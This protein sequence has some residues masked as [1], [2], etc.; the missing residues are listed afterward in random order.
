MSEEMKDT[1]NIME[2]AAADN[3]EQTALLEFTEQ[4]ILDYEEGELTKKE[5]ATLSDT[6]R[7]ALKWLLKYCVA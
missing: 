7:K 5:K 4:E 2:A 3:A 1:S 6:L